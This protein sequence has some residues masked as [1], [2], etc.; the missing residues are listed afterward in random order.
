VGETSG[1]LK[2]K[3]SLVELRKHVILD[4]GSQKVLNLSCLTV[5]FPA[6]VQKVCVVKIGD[7]I[8]LFDVLLKHRSDLLR[9]SL[10][11]GLAFVEPIGLSQIV[12]AL[13]SVRAFKEPLLVFLY[14]LANI[15]VRV[16]ISEE[17]KK[18]RAPD[19]RFQICEI[20]SSKVS[21]SKS[22][23]DLVS[24]ELLEVRVV[25]LSQL[26]RHVAYH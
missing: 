2:T 26:C 18:L 13:D 3:V 22:L 11:S 20:V 15:L 5:V 19:Q 1:S 7:L 9:D 8:H 14:T 17:F 21:F 25:S 6:L 23:R 24:S 4:S 10:K 16:L 12:Y